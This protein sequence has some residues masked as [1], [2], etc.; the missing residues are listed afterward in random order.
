[1]EIA[2]ADEHG[3]ARLNEKRAETGPLRSQS[4]VLAV[5]SSSTRTAMSAIRIREAGHGADSRSGE[6]VVGLLG[7][8]PEAEVFT[9]T[10]GRHL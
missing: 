7:E 6:R 2:G 8:L 10:L 1:M 9:D 3:V 4:G 5:P